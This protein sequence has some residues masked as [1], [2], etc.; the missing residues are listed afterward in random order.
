M[1]MLEKLFGFNPRETRPC[2]MRPGDTEHGRTAD[3]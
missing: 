3:V 1:K 2:S